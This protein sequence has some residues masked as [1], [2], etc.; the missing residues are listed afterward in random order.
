MGKLSNRIKKLFQDQLSNKV[1][2]L[3]DIKKGKELA[4]E[5]MNGINSVEKLVEQ[6]ISP[7]DAIYF[8]TQ[9]LVSVLMEGLIMLPPASSMY[10]F[11]SKQ[12]DLYGPG[13]P[14]QSP[15]TNSYYNLWLQF[16]AAFGDD[17]ET[18]GSCILDMTDILKID[19]IQKT[20]L[21]N[22]CDSRMGLYEITKI[23][24]NRNS[25]VRELLSN[26]TFEV[27]FD[28]HYSGQIGDFVY[29]R[30][31][32]DLLANGPYTALGVPYH[33]CGYSENEWTNYFKKHGIDKA[34]ESFERQLHDHMKQGKDKN[35]WTEYTFW[36][37]M[38]HRPDVI[39]LT[40]LPDSVCTQAAH[41][42]FNA[43][44][45]HAVAYRKI[46]SRLIKK[47]GNLTLKRD[48]KSL[49]L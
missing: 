22:L 7:S 13:Y 10:R 33:V 3:S 9:N 16:D 46:E 8:N 4:L 14:P 44:L 6:G 38:Q 39:Y 2:N 5:N 19:G 21:K 20:A 42:S 48:N 18:V 28:V 32:P 35:Y 45:K 31:L 41:Q 24:S 30:I 27:K 17:K 49:D 40:G 12:E 29:I 11:F 25:T 26:K 15:I 23:N 36:A 43:H 34:S 47:P 1:I 37:Y